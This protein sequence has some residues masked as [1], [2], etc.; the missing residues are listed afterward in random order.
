MN[1]LT[2]S[3]TESMSPTQIIVSDSQGFLHL[4]ELMSGGLILVQSWKGHGF[5]AW[6][7]A[8]NYETPDVFYS[9][10]RKHNSAR[11]GDDQLKNQLDFVMIN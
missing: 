2:L 3:L 10:E 6:I 1:P 8:F 9:G 7:A 4:F 5:E 11:S